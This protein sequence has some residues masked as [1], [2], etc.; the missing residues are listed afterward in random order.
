MAPKHHP[1]LINAKGLT[2]VNGPNTDTYGDAK[3]LSGNAHALW[4]NLTGLTG[5]PSELT[6]KFQME[7]DSHGDVALLGA[8]DDSNTFV[9][10]HIGGDLRA[11][12]PEMLA[13]ALLDET[14]GMD[15]YNPDTFQEIVREYGFE[16]AMVA[17]REAQ[18]QLTWPD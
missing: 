1:D 12:V 10:W 2:N 11:T 7:D 14:D 18:P 16:E 4:G 9:E 13:L 17:V 5:D 15:H 6:D 8:L 3:G